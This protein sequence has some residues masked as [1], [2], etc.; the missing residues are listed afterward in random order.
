MNLL[1]DLG[2]SRI[3]WAWQHDQ[4]L[5]SMGSSATRSGEFKAQLKQAWST[6]PKPRQVV[7]CAVADQVLVEQLESLVD[8]LWQLQARRLI[9]ELNAFGLTCHYHEPGQLGADRWA[10]MIGAY[11]QYQQALCVI[12]CG[13]AVTI[14][15]LSADGQHQGGLIIP[16]ELLMR[17]VLGER[18][19][20]IGQVHDGSIN[21]ASVD[22][23][24]A[25]ATGCVLAV[26]AFIDR[27]IE[28]YQDIIAET[29]QIFITG[30]DAETLLPH[31]K[32][33]PE[34][35]PDLVFLGLAEFAGQHP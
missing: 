10:A 21:L 31:L 28:S 26:A 6:Q 29:L 13:T 17:R 35:V 23:Q 9:P 12:D 19:G 1:V 20:R 32:S 3:K 2:N 34:M 11:T 22:T 8:E 25:V 4:I 5:N 14:D 16:G 15:A 18:T 24:G 27:A 30:G 33:K 7:Y